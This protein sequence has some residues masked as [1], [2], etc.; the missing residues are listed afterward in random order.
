M[1][2]P[3]GLNDFHYK[4]SYFISSKVFCFKVFSAWYDYSSSNFLMVAFHHDSAFFH[5]ST[6]SLFVSLNLKCVSCGQHVVGF[7]LFIQSHNLCL[8]IRMFTP[9]AFN[10]IIEIVGFTFTILFFV[11]C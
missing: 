7:G 5:P 1:Y 9:F 10:V 4:M 2:L 8:L 11:F 3:N 6:F